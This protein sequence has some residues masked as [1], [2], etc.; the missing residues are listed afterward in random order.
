MA[1]EN[2]KAQRNKELHEQQM[3]FYISGIMEQLNIMNE[4]LRKM[5][6]KEIKEQGEYGC[7]LKCENL[8][9]TF[10]HQQGQGGEGKYPRFYGDM[11]LYSQWEKVVESHFSICPYSEIGKLTRVVNCLRG[12]AKQWSLRHMKQL[13]CLKT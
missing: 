13:S 3:S 11:H 7:E 12:V 2:I 9:N 10:V 5:E 4:R 6:I 8:T 1:Q